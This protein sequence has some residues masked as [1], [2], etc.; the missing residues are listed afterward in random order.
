MH[1][2]AAPDGAHGA[3]VTPVHLSAGFVFDSFEHARE[4]F[5][6]EDEGYLYTRNGNPTTE[7]VERRLAD[8]EGGAEAILVASG[9]A[10]TASALL[11]ILQAGDRVLSSRRLYEGNRGLLVQNFGRLGIGV[12]FV[13]DASDLGEWERRIGPDT[14]VLFGEPIPNPKND[15]LD[16]AAL[17][18][19]AHRHGLP[20]VVDNTLATPYLL[21]PIEHG[22]DVVVHSTSKFLA[23]HGSALGGVIVDAGTFDW[24]ARPA[25]FPHLNQEERSFGGRS[26]AEQHGRRAFV[27]YTREIVVS[28]LGPTPSPLNSFL[29][30]QGVETLSLRVE[31][32]SANALA[33]ARF[34]EGRPEVVSVDYSGLESSPS[35]A[36]AQRLLPRGQGSVFSFTVAGGEAGAA[37]FIDAVELFSHMTHLGDVRSLVLHP[38]STTHAGRTPAERAAAGIHPGLLRLS[39]GIEDVD[40]LLRD[41]ERGLAAVR[42]RAL[43]AL[44]GV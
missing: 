14:R 42:A 4:R 24:A 20:F 39:I 3:R 12:D 38:A 28:R 11:G 19:I 13:D 26:W 6:G 21:R 34:L 44:A 1:A 15:L 40:D 9:Q 18:A 7:E 2:G 25:L 30:R 22:A 8:L 43:P 23:G 36:L 16:L 41:L 10:A 32:H 35:F 17:A 31:R 37:A 29:L 5:A 33:V 27:S